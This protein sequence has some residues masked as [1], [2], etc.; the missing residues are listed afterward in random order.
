MT[1][2]EQKPVVGGSAPA[3][4]GGAAA[5]DAQRKPEDKARPVCAY[6]LRNFAEEVLVTEALDAAGIEYT[7]E[8]TDSYAFDGL[9]AAEKGGVGRVLVLEDDKARAE[10]LIQQ[11]LREAAQTDGEPD[12][13]PGEEVAAPSP[14]LRTTDVLYGLVLV[15][16]LLIAIYILLSLI[17]ALR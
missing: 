9:F 11:C 15:G 10:E 5:S 6:T 14:A 12:R 13:A 17:G 4:P 2:N 8:S 3:Q 7:V 16:L 1:L